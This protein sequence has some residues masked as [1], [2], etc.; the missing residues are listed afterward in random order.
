MTRPYDPWSTYRSPFHAAS[1]KAGE[2]RGQTHPRRLVS[3]A[4]Q[5]TGV[6]AHDNGEFDG[7]IKAPRTFDLG[8]SAQSGGG[9]A[10]RSR[11]RA[12][13]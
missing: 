3:C 1:L 11:Y 8:H 4:T 12:P 10:I 6:E 7:A 13:S 2:G 9:P 5:N